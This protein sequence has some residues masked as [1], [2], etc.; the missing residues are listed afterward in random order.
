MFQ[1]E[2]VSSEEAMKLL[3]FS[4]LE[5]KKFNKPIAIAVCGPEGELIA[6]MRM[7]G[8]SPAASRIAQNKGYT[9]AIDRTETSKMGERM[10]ANDNPAFWGDE[11]VTGFGGGIPI[12]QNNKVIGGL[13][14]SGL[15]EADDIRVAKD[16]IK[17]VFG[18]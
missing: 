11:R 9:S 3:S 12:I 2:K 10:R 5:A 8:T 1:Y 16:A 18:Y 6:F 14:I 13:G 7:D 17:E 4:I 15:P